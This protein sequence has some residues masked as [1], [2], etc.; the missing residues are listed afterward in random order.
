MPDEG[1]GP[2]L[3]DEP[4]EREM[5]L[6]GEQKDKERCQTKL[7]DIKKPDYPKSA[8]Y[9][10]TI[11]T[12]VISIDIDAAGKASNAKLLAAAPEKHFGDAVLE[13]AETIHY[14]KG[15]VWEPSCSLEHKGKV[16]T[17]FFALG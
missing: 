6:L 15:D 7:A 4:T 12:V 13:S 1:T 17:F 2:F 8:L 14:A 10:G 16:F 9:A 11:G 5:R 3:N